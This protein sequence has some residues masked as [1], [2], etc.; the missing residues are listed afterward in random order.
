MRASLVTFFILLFALTNLVAGCDRDDDDTSLDDRIRTSEDA[1]DALV[2]YG[3][4]IE[5]TVDDVA[6]TVD[7]LRL[8]AVD[9]DEGGIPDESPEWMKAP[10]AQISVVQN[11]AHFQVVRREAGER[12]ITITP[13]D[14]VEF[15]AEHEPLKRYLP[16]LQ[17]EDDDG[18]LQ[19]EL[20]AVGLDVDDVRHLVHDMLLTKKLREILADEFSED[21]LWAIYQQSRDEADLVLARIRNTPASAE[22]DRAVD[23]YDEEIRAHYRENRSRFRTR[24]RVKTTILKA[25]SSQDI[26]VLEE[27]SQRLAD[28][29]PEQVS[30][31]M[32]LELESDVDV[33]PNEN[34]EAHRAEVGDTGVVAEG[35]RGPYAWLVDEKIEASTRSLDRPLRR[36]IASQILREEEGITPS[37]RLRAQE[38]AEILSQVDS[39]RPLEDDEVEALVTALEDADFDAFHTDVFSLHARGVIP[40]VGLAREVTAAVRDLDLDDPVTEPILDRNNVYVARLVERGHASRDEFEAELD[41][42]REQFL[43]RNKDRFVEQFVREYQNEQGVNFDLE[44]VAEHFGVIDKKDAQPSSQPPPMDGISDK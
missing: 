17:G 13:A 2:V 23:Q 43:E 25:S 24:P 32:D 29:D 27:A 18:I 30:E 20:D 8:L 4:E 10:Q 39:G 40:E 1:G 7:R 21:K 31:E 15:I 41:E 19:D 11:M 37:N 35:P 28:G 12:D 22:I 36:Q 38:A 42:F 9:V 33:S 44:P 16:L 3:G 6:R 26:E 34:P 5:I 14:E